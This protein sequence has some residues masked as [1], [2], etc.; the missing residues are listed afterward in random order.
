MKL[1]PKQLELLVAKLGVDLP[2]EVREALARGDAS[3]SVQSIPIGGEHGADCSCSTMM[4][5]DAE[6]LAGLLAGARA[7]PFQVGDVVR[8]RSWARGRFKWPR[9]DDRCIV[10]QVLGT[11]YRHGDS[12]TQV[13]AK[14][15]DIALAFVNGDGDIEEYLHDRRMFEKVGSIASEADQ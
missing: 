5:A 15:N 6:Q 7:A 13:P 1:T 4:P 9:D 8:L 12:N 2:G 11:P 10:T 14:L 3:I